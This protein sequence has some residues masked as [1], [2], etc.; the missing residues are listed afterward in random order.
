[1]LLVTLLLSNYVLAA[2]NTNAFDAVEC[3]VFDSNIPTNHEDFSESESERC[4]NE[5]FVD[6]GEDNNKC[7]DADFVLGEWCFYT[8]VAFGEDPV[9]SGEPTVRSQSDCYGHA[10]APACENGDDQCSW[11]NLSE[12]YDDGL[13]DE[14]CCLDKYD[15][16]SGASVSY[17]RRLTDDVADVMSP[18]GN[19]LGG[20]EDLD[21]VPCSAKCCAHY[22]F[23]GMDYGEDDGFCQA[24][25]SFADLCYD[26]GSHL[27][28][29]RS[30]YGTASDPCYVDIANKD[31]S[32]EEYYLLSETFGSP[33]CTDFDSLDAGRR[34]E[35]ESCSDG[36]YLDPMYAYVLRV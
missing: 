7:D 2:G 15:P 10:S 4:E 22:F 35:D 36:C 21:L 33:R 23:Q 3:D 1:M 27:V 14:A 32:D 31:F 8:A 25:G 26:D 9:V 19:W 16:M 6:D 11:I 5:Q 12:T 17:G 28:L 29:N 13:C 30:K 34:L 24:S 18:T 20:D